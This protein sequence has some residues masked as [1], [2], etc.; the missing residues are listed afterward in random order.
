MP[1]RGTMLACSAMLS[2]LSACGSAGSDATPT[3]SADAIFTSAAQ[4]FEAQLA[5]TPPTN[6]PSPSPSPFATLALPSPLATLALVSS[7]PLAGSTGKCDD[8]TWI[9][10]VTIPDKTKLDPGQKFI[11]TWRVQNIG[12]CTWTTDY[13]V[14]FLDGLDFQGTTKHLAL[15]VP[16][17]QQADLTVDMRAPTSPGDYYGRWQMENAENQRFGSILTVVIKVIPLTTP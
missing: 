7:T 12:T 14:V 2:L 4:T 6:T 15:S 5:L 13:K 16:P 3:L 17:E 9:A 1:M 8:S 10:D 11:K